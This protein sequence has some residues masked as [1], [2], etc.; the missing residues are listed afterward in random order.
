MTKQTNFQQDSVKDEQHH[1]TI[2]K[3]GVTK[4]VMCYR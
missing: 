1:A 4:I 3:R 2:I